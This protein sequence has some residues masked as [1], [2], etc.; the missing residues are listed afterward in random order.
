MKITSVR[1]YEYRVDFAHGPLTMSHGR[2]ATGQPSFVLRVGTDEGIEGWAETCP[3]GATYNQSFFAGERAAVPLLAEAVLGVDPRQLAR[4]NAAMD[5]TMLGAPAAKSALDIAC[6]DILGK[7]VDVPVATLLGGIVQSTIRLAQWLPI[8]APDTMAAR[9]AEHQQ[10]GVR[11]F[12]V[13]V[14]DDWKTDIARVEA[15]VDAVGPDSSVVVD[16]NGGWSLQS[17]LLAV[18]QLDD[19]PIHLEQPC[20]TLVDCAELRRHTSLPMIGDESINTLADLAM[21]KSMGIAGVNIKP[22]RVGG[23]TR[24]RLLRDAAQA[25]DMLIEVD[26]TFG[27]SLMTAHV[28]HLAASTDPRNFMVAAFSSDW[29][30][31]GHI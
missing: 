9:A 21:A 8:A 13:K 31:P 18:R 11:N 5:A 4:V 23:L 15:V 22:Q 2:T 20:R 24:A 10:A 16:A 25:L 12:Q 17:A 29:T 7:L 6:W 27:G 28:A 3:N 19:L 30:T 1:M 14:G 26:D